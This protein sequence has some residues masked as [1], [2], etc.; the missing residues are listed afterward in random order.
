MTTN[1]PGSLRR[2]R[3]AAALVFAAAL[4]AGIWAAGAGAE[5]RA[6]RA[7]PDDTANNFRWS[8]A[9]HAGERLEVHGINGSI[10]AMA[11]RGD[12]AVVRARKRGRRSDPGDVEVRVTKTDDGMR[13]CAHYP[14]PDGSMNEE[15]ANQHTQNNDVDVE[16]WV[17]VPAGVELQAETVNGNVEAGG[18]DADLRLAT[19]NGNIAADTRGGATGTT[20]NGNLDIR[21]GRVPAGG[22]V[23]FRTVNG[24][25]TLTVP[26]GLDASLRAA[27][28]N[29][30]IACDLP[31]AG[32]TRRSKHSL[33]GELGRGGPTLRIETVNGSI[34]IHG[35]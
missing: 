4:V 22:G 26:P 5:S 14:R 25:I 10:H 19:V 16:F 23:E 13:V 17:E 6:K 34:R 1:L 9:M 21:V 29:G 32:V 7:R 31:V 8:G 2:P 11:G 24:S 20:V 28:T 15:C 33:R 3:R 30:G 35:S 12:E 27:T 18:L